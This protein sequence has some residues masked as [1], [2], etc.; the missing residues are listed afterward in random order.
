MTHHL[1]VIN[2]CR[3]SA[4]KKSLMYTRKHITNSTHSNSYFTV[5]P[6]SHCQSNENWSYRI[7]C[8]IHHLEIITSYFDSFDLDNWHSIVMFH[9]DLFSV[10]LHFVRWAR[11]SKQFQQINGRKNKMPSMTEQNRIKL[12]S[13]AKFKV[14]SW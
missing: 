11:D 12:H 10:K 6:K 1:M 7:E 2:R 14:S 9:N 13:D 3:R 8:A 4:K 5:R